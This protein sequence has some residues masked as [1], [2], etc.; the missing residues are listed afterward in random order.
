MRTW[1]IH[2]EALSCMGAADLLGSVILSMKCRT[3]ASLPELTFDAWH[4]EVDHT[5]A[6]HLAVGVVEFHELFLAQHGGHGTMLRGGGGGG[7]LA[8]GHTS[9]T[10]SHYDAKSDSASERPRN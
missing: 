3:P 5:F 2:R 10:R 6:F 1:L 9:Q 7:G 8:Q 4:D